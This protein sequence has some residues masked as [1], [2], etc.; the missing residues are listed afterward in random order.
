MKIIS[1]DPSCLIVSIA[2]SLVAWAS[3]SVILKVRSLRG[4]LKKIVRLIG[5][6]MMMMSLF[7]FEVFEF[8]A[9]LEIL[10]QFSHEPF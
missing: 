8:L 10:C 3:S 9:P 5:L 4:F 2:E 7:E 1:S 6:M